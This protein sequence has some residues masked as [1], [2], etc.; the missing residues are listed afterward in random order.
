MATTRPLVA[1]LAAL[2]LVVPAAVAAADGPDA[3]PSLEVVGRAADALVFRAVPGELSL[4]TVETEAG[5]FTRLTI[6]GFH[7]SQAEGEPELPMMNR[8]LAIPRGATARVEIL[9]ERVRTVDLAGRGP[10]RR[11]LPHQPSVVKRDDA[12]PIPFRLDPDAYARLR[13]GREPVRV[14]PLGRLRGVDLARLEV[15]PAAW[16]PG[17]DKVEVHDELSF[18]VVFDRRAGREAPDARTATDDALWSPFFAPVYAR[19]A[20]DE[21]QHDL[22]PDLVEGRVTMVVVAPANF[23]AEMA[24]FLDWKRACG[25]TVIAA[26]TGAPEVGDTAESIRDFL[27]GLYLAATPEQPAPTFVLLVGDVDQV[28]TFRGVQYS[29][30]DRP[31]CDVDGDMFPDMYYGRWSAALPS[32]VAAIVA[33][34]LTYEQLTMDDPSYLAEV[35]L[36]SGYDVY[37]APLFGN[38][39][40]RYATQEYFN[41]DRAI[42]AH[43]YLHPESQLKAAEIVG[44]VSGGV[45]FIN[46]TA[47]GSQQAWSNPAFTR[48][49]VD[50]LKNADEYCFA[51]GNC[52]LTGA[53]DWINPS[54]A[55]DKVSF[56]ESW[57]RAPGKG[58]VGYI[59]GSNN[60]YWDEDYWWSVGAVPADSI[61]AYPT[62][63]RSGQGAYDGLFHEGGE[64]AYVT[65]AAMIFCGNLAVTEAGSPWTEYY[66]DIYNLQGDPSLAPW[67]GEPVEH[68][69]VLPPLLAPTAHTLSLQAEPGS[70]VGLTQDGALLAGGV[71][72]PGGVADLP[73]TGALVPGEARLV[74]TGQ[75]RAPLDLTLPVV[76]PATAVADPQTV[77]VATPTAVTVT[78]RDGE[79]AAPLPGIEV[80]IEGLGFASDAATTGADGK[81][82]VTADC[83]FGP[84]VDLVGRDPAKSY[85]EFRQPLTVEA[86]PL[87]N[88][89]LMVFNSLGMTETLPVNIE[90][91]ILATAGQSGFTLW[92]QPVSGPPVSTQDPVFALTPTQTGTITATIALAGHDLYSESFPVQRVFGRLGG[93][94]FADA[95]AA[96]GVRVL[97]YGPDG[98]PVFSVVTDDQGRYTV[99]GDLSV[100]PYTVSVA[101]F[102][103]VPLEEEIFVGLGANSRDLLLARGTDVVLD[104]LVYDLESAA[105]LAAELQIYR[106]DEPVLY[107]L[108]RTHADGSF[109][110]AG[111][112][113]AT[114][115]VVVRAAGYVP[116][117]R[118]IDAG[119]AGATEYFLMEPVRGDVLVLWDDAAR[120]MDKD[121]DAKG[122]P[123]RTIPAPARAAADPVENGPGPIAADLAALGYTVTVDSVMTRDP[124]D[125]P[126]HDLVVVVTGRDDPNIL[127]YKTPLAVEAARDTLEAYV[128]RGGKL[129]IEGGEL[130]YAWAYGDPSF[131]Q[132][133]LHIT[134]WQSDAHFDI[135][136]PATQH[137]ITQVPHALPTVIGVDDLRFADGDAVLAERD[138]TVVGSW[139]TQPTTASLVAYDPTPETLGGQIVFQAVRYGVIDP[140]L[141]P[142]LL[143]NSVNWLLAREPGTAAV[144]GS[145][146]LQGAAESGGVLVQLVPDG[147]ATFTA[148]DGSFRIERVR[149]GSYSLRAAHPEWVEAG[150]SVAVAEG[151]ELTG[152]V[153]SLLPGVPAALRLHAVYPNPFNPETTVAFDLPRDARVELAVFDPRGRRVKVLVAGDLPFGYHRENWDGRDDAGRTCASGVYFARLKTEGRDLTRKMTLLR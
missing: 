86:Q 19:L 149:A 15:S 23:M 64:G 144:A 124:A 11:L 95:E 63:E 28:P 37:N 85:E 26:E 114:Y 80:W 12:P 91:S 4:T 25:F 7:V 74:L 58:A 6:P 136:L 65:A 152:I 21:T 120:R 116:V 113:I 33:K 53:Y 41:L 55:N 66:W 145:V 118:R 87:D 110:F 77:P 78:V 46:Y 73:L 93:R 10:A 97:G 137:P 148:A 138:V 142:L 150:V 141:R 89:G 20:D 90:S 128:A 99:P 38:G 84:E 35:V 57:L 3:R 67:L 60:T 50:T 43:D 92:V 153:L 102:G 130:G 100:G 96:P 88:P 24:A 32:Q 83:P 117:V 129:L 105:P 72:G 107:A 18:R 94:V 56:A 13:V 104:G 5:P 126:A 62:W 59:G 123:A 2:F 61:S 76:Q 54:N 1:A 9:S 42:T 79:T 140:E 27:H 29:A 111:L 22:H 69:A 44:R 109:S 132:N 30:T 81:A 134:N 139:D 68:A 127:A 34:T 48:V 8:L 17:V 16:L 31:Y 147:G 115:R 45:G 70:F 75:N 122:A 14:V 40:I 51:V 151:E 39:Q 82:V 52:C 98:R 47:H 112:P 101:I 49:D 108:T 119:E 71:V 133:V 121:D 143:H 36:T 146:T 135:T 131:A 125:W 106:T 103:F